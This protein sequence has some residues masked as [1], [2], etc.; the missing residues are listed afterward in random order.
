ML[1]QFLPWQFSFFQIKLFPFLDNN[2]FEKTNKVSADN[3]K[4]FQNKPLSFFE[5]KIV[6]SCSR[7]VEKNCSLKLNFKLFANSLI[8]LL[9]RNFTNSKERPFVF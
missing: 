2:F 3:M 1:T 6:F 9:T 7:L 8:T 5:K 4:N